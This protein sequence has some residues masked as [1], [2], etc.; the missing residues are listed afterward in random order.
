MLGFVAITVVF[1]SA[2]LIA[3]ADALIK[4][5]SVPGD[6]WATIQSPWMLAVCGL[7]LIQILIVVYVFV[8]KGELAIYGNIFIV[9]YAIS[10]ILLGVFFFNEQLT[11]LQYVGIALALTGAVLLNSGL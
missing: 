9:F 2:I 6:F 3:V 7:Y 8:Q 5:A 1:V 4:K 11:T 10:M